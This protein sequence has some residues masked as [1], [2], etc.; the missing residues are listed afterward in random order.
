MSRKSARKTK[1][2]LDYQIYDKTGIKVLKSREKMNNEN[3]EE[4]EN[5]IKNKIKAQKLKGDILEHLDIYEYDTLESVD[6]L[7]ESLDAILLLSTEFRHLHVELRCDLGDETYIATYPNVEEFTSKVRDYIKN[8]K[9]KLKDLKKGEIEGGDAKLL[10]DKQNKFKVEEEV[11]RERIEREFQN[12]DLSDSNEIRESCIRLERILVE[13][14]QLLTSIKITFG[15]KFVDFLGDNFDKTI[16]RINDQIK[17]GKEKMKEI[18]AEKETSLDSIRADQIRVDQNNFISDK[19]S[20]ASNIL[21]ELELRCS[22]LITKCKVEDLDDLSDYQILDTHKNMSTKDTELREIFAKVTE[23]CTLAAF[24]GDKKDKLIENARNLE[25]ETLDKRNEYAKK[26]HKIIST[27]DISDE[28]LRNSNNLSIDLSKFQGYESKLD[29]YSFKTEFEKLIQPVIQKPYWADTLKKNYLSGPALILVESTE[30]I[31]EIWS[32]LI[33]AYGN[34]KLLFQNKLGNLDRYEKLSKIKNDEKLAIT[35]AKLLNSMT[36]LCTLAEKHNLKNKL[37]I[38]GGLERV[39]SLLGDEREKSFLSKNIEKFQNSGITDEVLREKMVWDHLMIY[40]KK[41]LALRENLILLKKSRECLSGTSG[42]NRVGANSVNQSMN[43]PLLCHICGESGHIVSTDKKG[44]KYID[45]VACESFVHMTPKSR[46]SAIVRNK[47]CLQCLSP[48]MKFDKEHTCYDTYV[49]PDPSHKKFSKGLHVLVCQEHKTS[50]ENMKILE[51]YK[52]NFLSKRA[53]K[54]EDFTIKV[55]LTCFSQARFANICESA[56]IAE[57]IKESAIFMMQSIDVNGL[58]LNFMYDT[59]CGDMVISMSAIEKLMV[60]NRAKLDVPGPIIISGVG[61]NK[62]ISKHGIYSVCLPLKN[63]NEVIFSGICLDD[64]TSEFPEYCLNEVEKDIKRQYR[65]EGKSLKDLPK[66]AKKVGGVT[67]ILFGIKYLLYHPQLVWKAKNGLSIFDSCFTSVDGSTGICGGPHNSFTKMN[68]NWF[69]N[70]HSIMAFCSQQVQTIRNAFQAS[71]ELPL[72]GYSH[73]SDKIE[74][75]FEIFENVEN[76]ATEVTFRCVDCRGCEKCKNGGRVEFLS[77]QEEVEQDLIEKCVNVDTTTGTTTAKLPFIVNPETKLV[78]NDKLALKIYESQIRMLSAKPDDKR[79]VIESEGKLQSLGYVV[80]LD[81]LPKED[82]DAILNA[83]GKYIIPWRLAYNEN[84]LSTAVR[85]VFDASASPRGECSLNDVLAKGANT[86]NNLIEIFIR[87]TTHKRAFHTDIKKM[88]NSLSLDK[89]H[90]QYQLYYWSENLDINVPPRIKVIPTVIYGVKPSGNLAECGLRKTAELTRE[91]YPDAY[92]VIVD[93]IYVDDCFSGD[94]TDKLVENKTNQLCLALVKG[95]FNLK[96]FTCSGQDPP[97]QLTL[98]GKSVTVGGIRWYSKE[99]EFSLKTSDLN[100]SKKKR[101]RKPAEF[102]GIIPDRL[103]RRDCVAKVAEIFDPLGRVTPITAALKLD[104]RNL[105]LL[106]LDWDDEIPANLREIWLS[107]FK[108]IKDIGDIRFNRAVIPTDAVDLNMET[109]DTADASESLICVA[110]YVRFKLK[111]GDYSCQLILARSKLLPKDTTIPRGELMAATMNASTG[112]IVKRALREKHIKSYKL[113]D[114]QVTLHWIGSNGTLKPYVRRRVIEINRLTNLND[115]GYVDSNN[116]IADLGT[117]KGMT[118]NDVGKH[119]KFNNG[120]KWMRGNAIHFPLKTASEIVLDNEARRQAIKEFTVHDHTPIE[121]VITCRNDL[122]A[123]Y[124]PSR[125]VPEVVS[126]RYKF[127]EYLIDPN[128]FRFR[129]VIRI[130][131][132][133]LLFLRNLYSRKNRQIKFVG[134]GTY[135]IPK[136]IMSKDD[137]FLITTGKS[138][139]KLFKCRGGLV[140]DVSEEMLKSALFYFFQKASLE[141]KNF[142]SEDRYKNISEDV[143]GVLHFTGRILPT[144][145]INGQLNLADACFDLCSASFHVPLVDKLSPIAYAIANET[146]WYHP[147]VKHGGTESVLRQVQSVAFILSGRNLVKSIKNSCIRCR[148]LQKRAIKVMM[149]PKD[150]TNLCISP[151]FYYTQVDIC[152]PYDSFSNANKR[153]KIKIWFV[154][155]CCSSTGAVDCKV[156]EDYSTDTFILAFIRFS[157]RYGYPMK[158]LADSGSQLVKGCSDMI[159]NL[160]D[161]KSKLSVEYG[162]SFEKCPVGAHYYQGKVERKIRQIQVSM[163]KELC[164]ER[165]SIVQWETLGQQ[166]ANSINNLPIGLG[167]KVDGLENLDVL[168]PNR[169]L[170]GRN[171]NR[172][173]TAPLTLSRDVK[174]IIDTNEKIFSAWF[175]S[176]LI[177]YVPSLVDR[178][179]WFKNDLHVSVGDI[180]LLSK[181]DKVFENLYQYGIIKKVYPGK[182]GRIR[183]VDVEYQNSG[184]NVKRT[185]KRGVRELVMIHPVDELGIFYELNELAIKGSVS[186]FAN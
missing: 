153:A 141:I 35:I 63:G 145:K 117:R 11:L 15:E 26:L 158:L 24:C 62:T 155:F 113:T 121:H 184:E 92:S 59:G 70:N 103:T 64:V 169:L 58:Q 31:T 181:S 78:P 7:R 52:R 173:P 164:N 20:Q 118:I 167:N 34:V 80:Y 74:D 68:Q 23:Y 25:K 182:D 152:G 30:D 22:A 143:N 37:Y 13:Y 72:L 9:S 168:T 162:V 79:A 18:N 109:I 77:I 114:S 134:T 176:W 73:L 132:L 16:L 39:L 160:S 149:G 119:S 84:S 179:K 45:Y 67:D 128:K 150:N 120:F 69:N 108:T 12:F 53:M 142:I 44:R 51:N 6:D 175:R 28:K 83:K 140:V 33:Q 91:L 138:P 40:L 41:E 122:I 111:T 185:T 136:I 183:A 89:S 112:F 180:V 82:Q 47:F 49:C 32:K 5:K 126:D 10:T 154:V 123:S 60:Q 159:L 17:L 76:S 3:T 174:K 161:L 94:D 146:H 186:L 105:N 148:L 156:M 139:N 21:K 38:G 96:G 99:D 131:A 97:E 2:D 166:I 144:Q 101:G 151:A 85:L 56:E 61:D 102:K 163:E 129:K 86:M 81:E 130:L 157:C 116:M 14:Y 170:L 133:V 124:F 66:L 19:N 55:S 135:S 106:N 43:S 172:S 127:S 165:L 46:R 88:Y 36:E 87:W 4:F 178:P 137:R 107:H 71:R 115:W 100:F 42:S 93:D 29:I 50:A 57:T 171:N 54:F 90:W 75:K 98:D 177:S 95:G 110:I 147:D 1:I 104:L 125:V 65:K 27:R 8:S 48:G